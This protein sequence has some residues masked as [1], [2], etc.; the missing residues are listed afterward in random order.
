M[1]NLLTET[2]RHLLFTKAFQQSCIEGTNGNT[3]MY[4]DPI[5]LSTS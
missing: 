4:Y 3:H 1:V 5:Y 2:L